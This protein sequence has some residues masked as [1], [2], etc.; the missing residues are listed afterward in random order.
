MRQRDARF[1]RFYPEFG[2]SNPG[3]QTVPLLKAGDIG[4]HPVFLVQ[5]GWALDSRARSRSSSA[6]NA[7]ALFREYRCPAL[8]PLQTPGDGCI[9]RIDIAAILANL[10]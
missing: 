7:P 5:L 4:P 1:Q 6:T 10:N 2:Y 9:E 3:L 8:T